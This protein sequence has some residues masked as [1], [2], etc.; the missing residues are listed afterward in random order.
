MNEMLDIAD[1]EKKLDLGESAVGEG[2][3]NELVSKSD[4]KLV[5]DMTKD[6]LNEYALTRFGTDLNL[7]ERVKMLRLKVATMIRDKLKIQPA[8]ETNTENITSETVTTAKNPEFIFNPKNRKIFEWTENLATREDLI[9]CYIVD[10][11]GKRL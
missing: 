7:A 9:E 4:I 11:K 5:M 8:S 1:E 3:R 10:K 6:E 2:H